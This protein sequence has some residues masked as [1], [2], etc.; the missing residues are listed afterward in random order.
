[1]NKENTP[2]NGGMDEPTRIACEY[3]A[4]ELPLHCA[5]LTAQGAFLTMDERN[6][7]SMAG[8]CAYNIGLRLRALGKAEP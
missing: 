3:A 5:T 1:M 2:L 4:E 7:L 8:A 6:C